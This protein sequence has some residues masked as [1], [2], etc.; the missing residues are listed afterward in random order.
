MNRIF[1]NTTDVSQ[2]LRTYRG[3]ATPFELT[4][5]DEIYVAT[6][7][8]F[9]NLYLKF[10][11]ANATPVSFTVEYWDSEQF[12]PM[13]EV[14]DHTAGLTQ[15]GYIDFTPDRDYS[16]VRESDST[17]KV[18][19]QQFKVYDKAWLKITITG[20]IDVGTTL[21]WVGQL[22]CDEDDLFGEFSDFARSNFKTAFEAGKTDWEEQR[23]LASQRVC[24][25]LQTNGI[26]NFKEQL[27]DRLWYKSAA[28]QKT[29]EIIYRQLGDD[30][31]DQKED[32]RLEYNKRI[33]RRIH[34]VDEDKD[35]R[36]DRHE[37]VHRTGFV[38]R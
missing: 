10:G 35:G 34:R 23:V 12:R 32:A 27:V 11:T 14:I 2:E 15:D 29:A 3:D 37:K 17:E 8:P 25:D 9:N 28:V 31:V 16:W 20:T 13:F 36:L 38:T 22:L 26:I 7:I 18:P 1:F 21:Q 5:G 24:E 30:F 19:L 4:T 6:D 33:N